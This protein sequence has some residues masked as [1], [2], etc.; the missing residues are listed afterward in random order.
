MD[1]DDTID[2][3]TRWLESAQPD[4]AAAL[5]EEA[6]RE[7]PQAWA[8]WQ[9]LGN[10]YDELERQDEAL[11]AY[12]RAMTCP[13]AWEGPIRVNRAVVLERLDRHTEALTEVEQALADPD[14]EPFEAEA[15]N[16]AVT[17]LVALDRA[18]DALD[19]ARTMLERCPEDADAPRRAALHAELAWALFEAHDD[20]DA[21]LAELRQ[22]SRL[23]PN[24][25][26]IVELVHEMGGQRPS[27]MPRQPDGT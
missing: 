26:R 22:A 27:W 19:L 25:T 23:H 14:R 16:V 24:N 15:I 6:L 1:I 9:L 18:D 13:D 12:A 2:Q 5:L 20:R 10:A 17:C 4:R 7:A 8:L 3:A 21:A 11:R